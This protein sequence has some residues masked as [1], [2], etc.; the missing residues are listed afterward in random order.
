[1]STKT[2]VNPLYSGGTYGQILISALQ[3]YPDRV[4]FE[5]EHGSYT[6]AETALHIAR[7]IG[8]L[9]ELGLKRGDTVAQLSGNR[10]ETFFL[11]AAIYISGLRSVTLHTLGSLEDHAYIIEDS[12]AALLV[13]DPQYVERAQA[14]RAMATKPMGWLSHSPTEGFEHFWTPSSA[15][16]LPLTSE[17]EPEDI[18]RLAYTGGTS[19]R[20]KGVMLSSRSMAT[21]AVFALSGL[22]WPENIRFLCPTPITHGA[23]ALILPT[24]YQGG[25]FILQQGFN[26]DKVLEA[27][28]QHGATTLFLVPTMIYALLDH[29]HIRTFDFSSLHSLMYGASPMAPA[30]IREALD[31][32]GPVLVQL[33]GQTEAPSTV[34][35]LTREDHL[36]GGEKRLAS[37]GKPYPGLT[38]QLLDDECQPVPQGEIGE[39]CVRGPLVMSGYWK[40]PAQTAK[41]LEGNWLHTGDL[42][43]QDEE[44]YVYIVDRK[45]DLIISGGFNVYPQEVENVIAAHEAV[46]MVAVIGVPDPKWGEAVKAVVV[47]KPGASTSADD[48]ISRVRNSKGPVAAPKSVD[49]VDMLPLTALGKPDKKALRGRYW[50]GTNR[51]VN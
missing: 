38:L 34:L 35:A 3:R 22:D 24:L 18:I 20:P 27:I 45:K 23:G 42:A 41:A 6:Y 5:S 7:A 10:P 4:A 17:V 21:N 29:P 16:T 2:A 11:L 8:R 49:F 31:V 25:T 46:S 47:L 39:I 28:S 36:L 30:R 12:E 32:F 40:Q 1:M 37:A 14:L 9:K 48:L 15:A 43:Y 26:R 51:A 44:G 33:Y 13:M 50:Q 19:G